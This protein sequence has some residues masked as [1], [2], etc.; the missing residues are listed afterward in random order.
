MTINEQ[1]DKQSSAQLNGDLG[2]KQVSQKKFLNTQKLK[3]LSNDHKFISNF[4]N[5]LCV[6]VC[7][8]LIAQLF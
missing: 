8:Y 1:D 6:V 2:S 5:V 3:V 4:L 7:I